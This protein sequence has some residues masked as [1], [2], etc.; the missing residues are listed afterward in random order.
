MIAGFPFVARFGRIGRILCGSIC[1]SDCRLLF[2]G[3]L[4]FG[5][6]PF[7]LLRRVFLFVFVKTGQAVLSYHISK[8]FLYRFLFPV[9]VQFVRTNPAFVQRNHLKG[10]G[11]RY[12]NQIGSYLFT[13]R[14]LTG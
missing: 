5:R 2:G 9:V 4:G 8:L 14:I 3:I 11:G 10:P 6:F 7:F 1:H 13:G 12:G